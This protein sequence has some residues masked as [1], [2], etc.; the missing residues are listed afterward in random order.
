MIPGFRNWLTLSVVSVLI[1]GGIVAYAFVCCGGIKEM[2]DGGYPMVTWS[3]VDTASEEVCKQRRYG[4]V[5]NWIHFMTF[6]LASLLFPDSWAALFS[7]GV[8]WEVVE[9]CIGWGDWRNIPF[10]AAGIAV[11][12]VTRK[13]L[14][15]LGNHLRDYP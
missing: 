11:G 9:Y 6:A 4:D 14:V 15:P 5:W 3:V 7:I 2:N 10:N 12:T 1:A 8:V 13:W